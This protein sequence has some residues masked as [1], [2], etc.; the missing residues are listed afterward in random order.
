[1]VKGISRQV[2]VV[3]APE[4]KL[5]EEVIFILRDE[6]REPGI[7]DKDLLQQAHKLLRSAQPA[8]RKRNAL[9]PLLWIGVGAIAVGLAW[10]AC[11]ML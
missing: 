3:R 9:Q 10:W 8:N 1:M 6:A 11:W 5:F 2:I 7:T 4:Q